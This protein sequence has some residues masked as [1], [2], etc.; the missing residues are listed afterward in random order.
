LNRDGTTDGYTAFGQFL[1]SSEDTDAVNTSNCDMSADL[2]ELPWLEDA[3]VRESKLQSHLELKTRFLNMRRRWTW[4]KELVSSR[5]IGGPPWLVDARA[6][7]MFVAE[8]SPT[9]ENFE[10][11]LFELDS[12]L[13][14]HKQGS[15]SYE[16]AERRLIER[17][18]NLLEDR[19]DPLEEAQATPKARGRVSRGRFAE[20]DRLTSLSDSVIDQFYSMDEPN[21]QSRSSDAALSDDSGSAS[22]KRNRRRKFLTRDEG[23][24]G[25]A[26]ESPRGLR[27][28]LDSAR[29][30]RFQKQPSRLDDIT[31]DRHSEETDSEPESSS[32]S[33]PSL[34]ESSD[35][36][37]SE[38][39]A[40]VKRS[41]RTSK[42]VSKRLDDNSHKRDDSL[43]PD[44]LPDT[45]LTHMESM[46]EK[47]LEISLQRQSDQTPAPVMTPISTMDGAFP[48]S[49][50]LA[51]AGDNDLRRE[52][53][54]LR[55]EM[56]ARRAEENAT[57]GALQLEVSRLKQQLE[58]EPIRKRRFGLQRSKAK[59]GNSE[60]SIE[61][62]LK[63]KR[64]SEPKT[65]AAFG[66]RRRLASLGSNKQLDPEESQSSKDRGE[67]LMSSTEHSLQFSSRRELSLPDAPLGVDLPETSGDELD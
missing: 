57:I 54:Q 3:F 19:H 10:S 21:L 20:G 38:T 4:E 52:I 12:V 63:P 33:K 58:R 17:R 34:D 41:V 26:H 24:L 65:K 59:F 5:R 7:T 55:A 8:P 1:F 47:L 25:R 46:L 2:E 32:P 67:E 30:N 39:D 40:N 35:E 62:N 13:V 66:L 6:K 15:I 48:A 18:D 60:L 31:E 23:S 36:K 9:L 61:E 45:R 37:D 29:Q 42:Q 53:S 51:P 56:E 64:D 50:L 44:V 16:E 28:A 11:G 22:T 43:A 14:L 49:P 27:T